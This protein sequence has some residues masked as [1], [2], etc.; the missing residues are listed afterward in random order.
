MAIPASSR[1]WIGKAHLRESILKANYVHPSQFRGDGTWEE[2]DEQVLLD[3]RDDDKSAAAPD[4]TPAENNGHGTRRHW[5]WAVITNGTPASC[6]QLGLFSLF[7]DRPAVDLV[8]AGP[9]HG[10]NASS[11]YNL[12]SG[13]VGGA[14]E[15]ATCRKPGIALSFGSKDE[16]PADVIAAAARL[17]VRVIRHLYRSWDQ[18]AEIYNLNVPMRLDVERRPVL[19]TTALRNYW[20]TGCLYAELANGDDDDDDDKHAPCTGNRPLEENGPAANAAPA[21]KSKVRCFAFAP[22]LSNMKKD[23]QAGVEGTDAHAVLN[24]CTR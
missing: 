4:A 17:A 22:D 7:P 20:S 2:A 23:L 18:G 13:T 8:V 6:V 9:N 21:A 5:P 12:S 19:Y 11:I 1:S 14:L 3:D 16:Q 10:R 24:G 15:A